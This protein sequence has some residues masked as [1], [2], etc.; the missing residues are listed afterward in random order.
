MFKIEKMAN[1][2]A[3]K[4][5]SELNMDDER[6]A[7]IAY[8]AFALI[9]AV[10][11]IVL[12][13]IFGWMLNVTVEAL[14]IS[15]VVSI[16]RKYSGGIHASTSDACTIIGTAIFIGLAKLLSFTEPW[17]NLKLVF[18][19]MLISFLWSYYIAFK[20]APVESASKP[21]SSKK[22]KRM[23]KGSIITLSVYLSTSLFIA[24]LYYNI[25]SKGLLVYCLCICAGAVWQMFTLTRAGYFVLSK[26][27][28]FLNHMLN[29]RGGE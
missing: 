4:I 10:I 22:K 9:Q 5:S 25:E 11:S 19:I 20:L 29:L 7:V 12:V 17:I 14:I 13:I 15:F 3:N 24:A 2:V 28:A 27:D 6:R 21:I 8:G 16:L 26:I 18:I 1:G 23:K